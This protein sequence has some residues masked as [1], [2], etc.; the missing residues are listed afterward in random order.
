M[1][2]L[3]RKDDILKSR[4]DNTNLA[5]LGKW[6]IN[7]DNSNKSSNDRYRAPGIVIKTK[8][9]TIPEV[10]KHIENCEPSNFIY[11]KKNEGK[12]DDFPYERLSI[13]DME[14]ATVP[15]ELAIKQPVVKELISDGITTTKTHVRI[16]I[17]TYRKWLRMQESN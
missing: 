2:W 7:V 13:Q 10:V 6:I 17:K 11:V 15:S 1:N 16:I 3:F 9:K 5:K 4:K 12:K 14:N 8:G